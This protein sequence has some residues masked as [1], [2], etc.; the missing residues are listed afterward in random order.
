[1]PVVIRL[2]P[3]VAFY[4]LSRS[5]QPA[6][7]ERGQLNAFFRGVRGGVEQHT[8]TYHKRQLFHDLRF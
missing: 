3:V 1:M 8:Q 7:I 2:I 4:A 6:V 5:I